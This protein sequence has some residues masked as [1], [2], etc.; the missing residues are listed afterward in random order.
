MCILE[1]MI[2]ALMP[3]E[4]C[5]WPATENRKL[6]TSQVLLE[7]CVYHLCPQLR[8][9]DVDGL[10]DVHVDICWKMQWHHTHADSPKRRGM[11][12][13]PISPLKMSRKANNVFFWGGGGD[14][15]LPVFSFKYQY[16]A[17]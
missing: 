6:S 15:D 2:I 9:T 13:S 11:E 5:Y 8:Q 17:A 14:G 7:F 1:H 16:H 10:G 12:A 4:N 3:T